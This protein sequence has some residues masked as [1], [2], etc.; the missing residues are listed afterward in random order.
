MSGDDGVRRMAGVHATGHASKPNV[1]LRL[2]EQDATVALDST[3]ADAY[4]TVAQARELAR[5]LYRLARR[6]ET[7][8]ETQ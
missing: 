1:W 4:L 8:K 5:Q 7:R 2:S 3:Y 6:I